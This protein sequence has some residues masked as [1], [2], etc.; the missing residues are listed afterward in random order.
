MYK[1]L[2]IFTSAILLLN[3][4]TAPTF[5]FSARVP[6]NTPPNVVSN[7]ESLIILAQNSRSRRIEFA[8]GASTAS[9]SASV[10]RGDR[11]VYVLRADRGQTMAI[12]INSTQEQGGALFDVISPNGEILS[13]SSASFS[14]A[15]V[16]SGDYRIIVGGSRGNASFSMTVSIN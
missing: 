12:T 13:S 11:A 5:A 2:A 7:P 3:P 15:L 14:Q 16:Q 8:P 1:S 6:A 10:V 4:F 9:V